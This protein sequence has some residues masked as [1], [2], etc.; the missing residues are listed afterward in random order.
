MHRRELPGQHGGAE[1]EQWL[2]DERAEQ[3]VGGSGGGTSGAGHNMRVMLNS[4]E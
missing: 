2:S 3:V 1:R 4:F